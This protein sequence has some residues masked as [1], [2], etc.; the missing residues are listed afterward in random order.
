[1]ERLLSS[2]I[3]LYLSTTFGLSQ[4]WGTHHSSEAPFLVAR[5]LGPVDLRCSLLNCAA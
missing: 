5:S 3:P 1:M 4:K 2:S